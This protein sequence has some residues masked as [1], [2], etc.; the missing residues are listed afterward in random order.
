MYFA[1][2]LFLILMV[3]LKSKKIQL[4][5]QQNYNGIIIRRFGRLLNKI[6]F[7]RHSYFILVILCVAVFAGCRKDVILTDSS[8]RL[9]FS[10]DT[11][12]FDTV[13]TT[14]GSRTEKLMV[15]NPY[16]STVKITSV[17][18]AGGSSSLFKINVDGQEGPV[19]KD[20][21]I[22]AKDSAYI[23]V[24]V[25]IDP[26]KADA[27]ML[28]MDSIVFEVNGN[29]QSVKLEAWGQDVNLFQ[30]VH[31]KTTTWSPGK[32]YLI[33]D[34]VYVDSA[35][36]LTIDAGVTLYFHRN[37]ILV[38]DGTL[39][40]NGTYDHHVI[41]RG[42]RLDKLDVSPPLSYD[43]V[44]GQWDGLW[45]RNGSSGNVFNYADIRNAIVG[46]HVGT[47]GEAGIASVEL[48]NCKIENH[49]YYGI[50]AIDAKI[51]AY[52]CLIDNCG[53]F[54]FACVVGGEYE[55]YHCTFANYYSL[56]DKAAG[57]SVQLRNFVI[58]TFPNDNGGTDTLK[59]FDVLRKAYFGNCIIAGS[60]EVEFGTLQYPGYQMDYVFDHCFIRGT[61]ETI[62][63]SDPN[64]FQ[65]TS[66][67]NVFNPGFISVVEDKYNF[68]LD[69]INT[70]L[71]DKG[72]MD[73][74]NQYPLDYLQHS[75]ISDDGPDL[76]LFERIQK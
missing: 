34:T 50:F 67:L 40:V 39:L 10:V 2:T 21:E 76:G 1:L 61:K 58:L 72:S 42:D 24:Q 16:N 35:E 45:I 52:N 29:I 23:W 41:F 5:S 54:T 22:G 32:P 11:L 19:V 18:I 73:I 74:A 46:L 13:F 4:I 33:K 14:I 51:K 75:R 37:G 30:Q 60:S 56:A 6:E 48:A 44:P 69:S 55:F 38:V 66:V 12:T 25:L 27:P 49:S 28:I 9:K 62:D 65:K 17:S 20:I 8:V 57:Y 63:I 36:T 47:L 43:Q 26:N 31:L 59:F 15:Y 64:K 70:Y 3:L 68:Q 53:V 71:R 7:M